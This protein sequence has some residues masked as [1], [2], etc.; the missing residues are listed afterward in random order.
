MM[1]L[2]FPALCDSACTGST[3]ATIMVEMQQS[4][5]KNEFI[6]KMAN[7]RLDKI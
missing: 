7:K 1:L 4:A 6:K 2:L 3:W 5:S